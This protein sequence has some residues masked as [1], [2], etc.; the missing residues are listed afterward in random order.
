MLTIKKT[1]AMN[2]SWKVRAFQWKVVYE[3]QTSI[4]HVDNADKIR[5][6][7]KISFCDT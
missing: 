3:S 2:D 5:L 7:V 6:L 1:K 4:I